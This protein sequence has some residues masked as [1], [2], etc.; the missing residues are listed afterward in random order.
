MHA[1]LRMIP[2][3]SALFSR[4]CK[5]TSLWGRPMLGHCEGVCTPDPM[6]C[7]LVCSST[8]NIGGIAG[9]QGIDFYAISR[10]LLGNQHEIWSTQHNGKVRLV[11]VTTVNCRATIQQ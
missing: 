3:E 11:F 5:L 1:G 7:P 6:V 9:P 4:G 8:R 10:G 2:H